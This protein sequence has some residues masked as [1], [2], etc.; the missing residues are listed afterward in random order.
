MNQLAGRSRQIE[1]TRL[2]STHF[3][4]PNPVTWAEILEHA[5]ENGWTIT[6]PEGENSDDSGVCFSDGENYVWVYHDADDRGGHAVIARFGRN[7]PGE[8]V[9]GC[10]V[11]GDDDYHELMER[12]ENG[13]ITAWLIVSQIV[14]DTDDD[15]VLPNSLAIKSFGDVPVVGQDDETISE[16]IGEHVE[17]E[18]DFGVSDY[19]VEVV[20]V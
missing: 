4:T 1:G 18:F 6:T 20:R 14:W 10:Y 7:D 8:M 17:E 11:E 19:K 12:L 2:M 16:R 5:A 13:P 3:I 9:D 15:F